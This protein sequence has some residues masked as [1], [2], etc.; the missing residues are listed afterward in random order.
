[1]IWG[2][3]H[4]QRGDRQR[5]QPGGFH[6]EEVRKGNREHTPYDQD[7]PEYGGKTLPNLE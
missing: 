1:M 3:D 7:D 6:S 2:N 5:V 4:G